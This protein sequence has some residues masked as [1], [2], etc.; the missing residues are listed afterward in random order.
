M[1]EL[2]SH[3]QNYFGVNPK[4]LQSIASFFKKRTLLKGD[5][6]IKEGQYVQDLSFILDGYLRIYGISK[7]KEVTQW[8]SAKNDFITDIA[9]LT[10]NVPS[11][12]NI[13]AI[14]DTMLFSISKEAYH[15]LGNIVPEWD[16]IEKV[17]IAKCF[18]TLEDRVY[19]FLSLSAEERYQQLFEY[20][21]E[22]FHSVPLQYIAS[23]LGMTPET[24]SRIRRKIKQ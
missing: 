6:Y 20:R 10:F 18:A 22:L 14:E 23:M 15:N 4:Y 13:V 8:I 19:G 5:F 7:G 11:R 2:E 3:I 9:S 24:F 21:S 17:F 12:K 16:K 1:N